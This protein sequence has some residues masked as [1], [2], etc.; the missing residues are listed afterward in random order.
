MERVEEVNGG[1][2]GREEDLGDING[3]A[4]PT[5]DVLHCC[6]DL[7]LPLNLQHEGVSCSSCIFQNKYLFVFK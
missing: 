2:V 5:D 6:L 1:L 7:H 4:E 3:H